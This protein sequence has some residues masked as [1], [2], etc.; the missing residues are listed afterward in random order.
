MCGKA[1]ECRTGHSQFKRVER[2]RMPVQPRPKGGL[3]MG[4]CGV[5]FLANDSPLAAKCALP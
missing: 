3:P 5:A 4:Q 2:R 1:R